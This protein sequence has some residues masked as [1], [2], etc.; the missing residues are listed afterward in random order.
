MYDV[1]KVTLDYMDSVDGIIPMA[2]AV[3]LS[4][5]ARSNSTKWHKGEHVEV[6]TVDQEADE[7]YRLLMGRTFKS[8][9]DDNG[10]DL[11]PHYFSISNYRKEEPRP[12]CNCDMLEESTIFRGAKKKYKTLLTIWEVEPEVGTIAGPTYLSG[13]RA[14]KL[15]KMLTGHAYKMHNED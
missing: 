10:D 11:K 12:Q 14:K 5:K 1:I 8:I 15:I 7:W 13:S 9:L 6:C 4:K 2:Y 3:G